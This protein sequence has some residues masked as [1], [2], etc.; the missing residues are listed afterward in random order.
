MSSKFKKYKNEWGSDQS[1]KWVEG[2][3]EEGIRKENRVGIR[4]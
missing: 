3:V 1:S 2:V 4:E